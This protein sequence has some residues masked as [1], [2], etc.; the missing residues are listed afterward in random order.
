MSSSNHPLIPNSQDY[1]IYKKYVSIHSEDI[2]TSK[3]SLN[4]FE[5]ELPQ[6]YLNVLSVK[7][8]NATFPQYICDFS[9][10][11]GNTILFFDISLNGMNV[12]LFT[13]IPDTNYGN[14]TTSIEGNVVSAINLAVT[15]YTGTS[16][17]HF[18]SVTDGITKITNS[19]DSFTF[20]NGQPKH[21]DINTL[22]Q[23]CDSGSVQFIRNAYYDYMAGLCGSNIL[24][25]GPGT[26][27]TLYTLLGFTNKHTEAVLENGVYNMFSP[28]Y[29][30]NNWLTFFYMDIE[31]M[32]TID[33]VNPYY[34]NNYTKTTSG[35][36]GKAN[37]AFAKIPMPQI[38]G[39]GSKA[40]GGGAGS[41]T[42]Y[43]YNTSI[44]VEYPYYKY[45]NPPAER[46][47]KLKI[48]FRFH[49]NVPVDF[50][51]QSYT[52]VLE[53]TLYDAH[54]LRNYHLSRPVIKI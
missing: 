22:L 6:D 8:S 51:G 15:A 17:S 2:D 10:A 29:I 41:S 44:L 43:N 32:N 24:S 35:N 54:I 23:N 34:S 33:E 26:N 9:N 40:G 16:Y 14:S 38:Y 36:S 1:I 47:K 49:N 7:L 48:R 3:Y 42:S 25:E 13:I 5:L 45:Y 18:S 31:G 52:F 39:S 4:D 28:N 20:F 37:S 30:N 12:P 46:I 21:F 19:T 11:L 53:F 27:T 50:L